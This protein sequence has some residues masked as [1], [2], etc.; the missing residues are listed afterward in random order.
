MGLR[1]LIQTL[2]REGLLEEVLSE[3]KEALCRKREQLRQTPQA[4]ENLVTEGVATTFA[5][6]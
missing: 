6:V 5:L 1:A 2:T 4:Q 3:G